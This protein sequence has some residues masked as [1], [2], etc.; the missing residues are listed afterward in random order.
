LHS[1]PQLPDVLLLQ[2]SKLSPSVG[3]AELLLSD[4]AIH[5]RDRNCF[6]G[7]LLTA[8]RK[9]Y[10]VVDF[11]SHETSEISCIRFRSGSHEFSCVNVYS[12]SCTDTRTLQ[13]LAVLLPPLAATVSNKSFLIVGGDFNTSDLT[14]ATLEL[15]TVGPRTQSLFD[16]C[17]DNVCENVV[18]YATR[19]SAILDLVFVSC[20]NIVSCS[21]VDGVS[22]H[23]GNLITLCLPVRGIAPSGFYRNLKAADWSLASPMFDKFLVDFHRNFDACSVDENY[24]KIK[25]VCASVFDACVPLRKVRSLREPPYFIRKEIALKMRLHRAI[26]LA[27]V[28]HPL[29]SSFSPVP[30]HLRLDQQR[31]LNGAVDAYREQRKVVKKL[32]R[33]HA[34]YQLQQAAQQIDS[35]PK[36][37]WRF[38]NRFRKRESM[39]PVLQHGGVN[40]ILPLAKANVLADAFELSF[41][42]EP[43]LTDLTCDELPCA[44]SMDCI[45][46]SVAGV[47]KLLKDLKTDKAAGPDRIST[48]VLQVFHVLLG[49]PV[50]R[51]FQQSYDSSVVPMDW[52]N[53]TVHPIPK[54][55]G[56]SSNPFEY[57]PISLTSQLSK[58]FEH[59]VVSSIHRHLDEH[60]L[61]SQ[62]QHGFRSA[63]SCESALISVMHKWADPLDQL[64]PID[65]IFLDF[66]KAFDRVPH[67]R[68][69]LKLK[70][71]GI[72]GPTVSWIAAFL[73]NRCFSV[74]VDG[75][76]SRP[77]KVTSGV[78][79]GSVIGPLLFLLFINDLPSRVCSSICMYADDVMLYRPLYS[80]SCAFLLQYDLDMLLCW[81]SKWCL[82]FNTGKCKSMRLMLPG[83]PLQVPFCYAMDTLRLE[84]VLVMRYL[85]I[86]ISSNLKWECHT[87][88]IAKKANS[89]IG[90]LRRNFCQSPSFMRRK[91]YVTLVRPL[92]EFCCSA[93][94]P[95]LKK[96]CAFLEAVQN[97]GARFVARDFIF[98]SSVTEMKKRFLLEP[99][100]VRRSKSRVAFFVKY[101]R[102]KV[103]APGLPKFDLERLPLVYKENFRRLE[104]KHSFL[105]RTILEITEGSVAAA[106]RVFDD[107]G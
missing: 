105:F 91:L 87:S 51:L 49:S 62:Y 103:H 106:R 81:A 74:R 72:R 12:P 13:A 83:T 10:T 85:G 69:L 98:N 3:D 95:F 22:D 43:S 6:G 60:D 79:Q 32:L 67:K 35:E 20:A 101:N 42:V 63:R 25:H 68:L 64:V 61:L 21:C 53:A 27:E 46:F 19:G 30:F 84:S 7:G 93:W 70:V 1:L 45:S 37:F 11:S 24:E 97:R 104:G 73:A 90:L 50:T 52:L 56:R 71:L 48:T 80:P 94:D 66:A 86:H 44:P 31:R 16:L 38:V 26:K 18:T 107:G 78:P 33:A 58:L 15:Y 23:W 8:V 89:V 92:L 82:P 76:Y 54:Q 14:P 4:Y 2:E 59:I 99:L 47:T 57:R 77:V 100:E 28:I 88:H 96:D 40:V 9:C 34:R 5:R 102:S 75:D 36:K 39:L 41:C 17:A 55:K 65:V 29:V